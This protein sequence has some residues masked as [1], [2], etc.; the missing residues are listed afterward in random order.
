VLVGSEALL[1][2]WSRTAAPVCAAVT[3]L[4]PPTARS[5]ISQQLYTT[6]WTLRLYDL[7]V[8]KEEYKSNI[9]RL[10]A[11]LESTKKEPITKDF[12]VKMKE[13]ELERLTSLI[14]QVHCCLVQLV[15][16][17]CGAHLSTAVMMQL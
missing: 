11:S 5:S 9:V 7:H 13:V 12:T 8:P 2:Q 17:V 3:Q 15:L 14:A 6:F 16:A 4:L 1:A 10:V